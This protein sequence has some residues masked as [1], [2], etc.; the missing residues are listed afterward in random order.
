M[1]PVLRLAR[2]WAP[3]PPHSRAPPSLSWLTARCKP[4]TFSASHRCNSSLWDPSKVRNL[5]IIAHIDAG[6]TTTTERMLHYA[7]HTK[8]IGNVDDGSTVMDFMPQERERGITIQSAA[9]TF[10]WTVDQQ[11]HQVNLVDTPGHVDFTF[12]VERSLRVLDG[13]VAILDGVAGVEA[14]TETVWAQANKYSVPRIAF[15]NK[16]DRA[17]A[18]IDRA[19]TGIRNRLP[20]WGPPLVIQKPLFMT[21]QMSTVGSGLE[22]VLD[23]VGMRTL[24]WNP[25]GDKIEAREVTNPAHLG[26]LRTARA[27]LVDALAN[28]SDDVLDAFLESE[29]PMAVPATVLHAALRQATLSAQ[30]VPVLVGAS[31]RNM[32]VQP[33][34]DAAMRYLPSPADRPPVPAHVPK[35]GDVMI[36][37]ED[38]K[39]CA[40]AFKV[41]YDAKRGYLTYVRVYAGQLAS[42]SSIWNATRQVK[43]RV[44]KV[45]LMYA[46]DSEEIPHVDP[47][48]IA[49]ILGFKDT[50]TGDTLLSAHDH[51]GPHK[52]MTLAGLAPPA[53]VFSAAI[54]AASASDVRDLATALEYMVRE[55]PS[56]TVAEHPDTG[57]TLV[58]GM[59]ELHLEIVRDRLLRDYKVRASMGPVQIAYREAVTAPVSLTETYTRESLGGTGNA[60][61]V[62]IGADLVPL[63]DARPDGLLD[64]HAHPN[65]VAV[66]A[67]TAEAD[68][69]HFAAQAALAALTRGPVRGAPVGNAKLAVHTLHIVDAGSPAPSAG[70]AAAA[71]ASAWLVARMLRQAAG[72]ATINPTAT[73]AG[74][75]AVMHPMMKVSV[76]APADKVGAVLRDLHRRNG[77]VHD[78]GPMEGVADKQVIACQV[79]LAEM[80]GYASALRS[81]TSGAG[82]FDMVLD[83]YDAVMGS[84]TGG[85]SQ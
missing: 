46:Q 74:D 75:V 6:K 61:V 43:E 21:D 20:G 25:E 1:S 79:P 14:Q 40:L 49:V 11:P 60:V 71:A 3:L 57:Q 77:R 23:V 33:L 73:A 69:K 15:V 28:V 48:N 42:R 41:V 44:N 4:A 2:P 55:D 59:G 67:A 81:L 18:N 47:G 58:S 53:P 78:V 72:G 83:G 68:A 63:A 65:D 27:E 16:M 30:G 12:E 54:E 7:G 17:G 39:L 51:A 80:I 35:H 37:L 45:L 56:V 32:G 85:G 5:G 62:E 82:T 8:R 38:Q 66:T 13:A 52:H 34:L 64:L 70:A 29:D 76:V 9:I 19:M 36:R 22:G 24:H 50:F 84:S 10:G 26:Q 31:F